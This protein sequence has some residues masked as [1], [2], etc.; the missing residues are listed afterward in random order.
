MLLDYKYKE[1]LVLDDN[2]FAAQPR[3]SDYWELIV[4]KKEW[5]DEYFYNELEKELKRLEGF[6]PAMHYL[7]TPYW[8]QT[9]KEIKPINKDLALVV[10]EESKGGVTDFLYDVALDEELPYTKNPTGLMLILMKNMFWLCETRWMPPGIQ[11]AVRSISGPSP[12]VPKKPS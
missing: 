2:T 10:R 11:P 12:P 3:N 6:M 7:K 8:K 5:D 9:Y 4:F 1:I